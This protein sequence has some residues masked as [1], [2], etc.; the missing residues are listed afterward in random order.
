MDPDK[1]LTLVQ[2]HLGKNGEIFFVTN[3][4]G[5]A[6]KTNESESDQIVFKQQFGHTGCFS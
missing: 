6:L 3:R 5:G 4:Q 1:K 2:G